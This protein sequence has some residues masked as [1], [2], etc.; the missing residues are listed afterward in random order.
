MLQVTQAGCMPWFHLPASSRGAAYSL[1]WPGWSP[2]RTGSFTN[3]S[4]LLLVKCTYLII[5]THLP[6]KYTSVPFV[7]HPNP[8]RTSLIWQTGSVIFVS[9]GY[10]SC[11]QT[12]PDYFYESEPGMKPSPVQFC[13]ATGASP[14][15]QRFWSGQRIHKAD[16]EECGLLLGSGVIY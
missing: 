10:F 16:Q 14:A 1:S 5:H 2:V 8:A 7:I 4:V 6:S 15:S 3:F 13:W 12:F 11:L 9:N